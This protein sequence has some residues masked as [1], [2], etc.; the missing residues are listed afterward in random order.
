MSEEDQI[1]YKSTYSLD[2][3]SLIQRE[4]FLFVFQKRREKSVIFQA[5]YLLNFSLNSGFGFN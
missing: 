3:N 2:I 4:K 1:A 5:N